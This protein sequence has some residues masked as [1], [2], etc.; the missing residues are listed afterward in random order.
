MTKQYEAFRNICSST[1]IFHGGH[2]SNNFI[3]LHVYYTLIHVCCF[4]I[5]ILTGNIDSSTYEDTC[6]EMFGVHAYVVFT[7][8][9]LVQNIVRQVS[10]FLSYVHIANW[11]KL[12]LISGGSRIVQIKIFIV[13]S[14]AHI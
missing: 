9:R 5:H 7:I 3:H 1:L 11:F 6:R 12:T 10:L 2:Y 14:Y 8:D 13:Y 4:R